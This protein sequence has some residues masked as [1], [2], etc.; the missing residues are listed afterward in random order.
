MTPP[1]RWS[2]E[3]MEITTEQQADSI[4]ENLNEQ[5]R[6]KLLDALNKKMWTQQETTGK[7]ELIN[8]EH[9]EHLLNKPNMTAKDKENMEK[10][11]KFL[12][13]KKMDTSE[14]IKKLEAINY[15]SNHIEIWGVKRARENLKTEPNEK[16]IFKHGD[17]VYFTFNALK[18]QN[19][20]LADQGMEIPWKANFT[21]AL[22]ALPWEFS[23]SN[24]YAGAN[25]LWNI[26]NLSM[27]GWCNS[28]G[29]LISKGK[30]GCVW[31]SSE[32]SSVRAR[33]FNFDGGKGD[34]DWTP[35]YIALAVRPV[36]K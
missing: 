3:D 14:N 30:F 18:E 28:D 9:F 2:S 21:K 23:E 10:S 8:H 31:S 27:S 15:A 17:E 13:D 11:I 33:A 29:T 36:L 25:I 19:K 7:K 1:V 26:L 5:E 34:L 12:I 6:K 20:L 32:G 24:R 22:K 35:R 4:V 16:N